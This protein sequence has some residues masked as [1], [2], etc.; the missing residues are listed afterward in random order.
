MF[1]KYE[2]FGRRFNEAGQCGSRD[3]EYWRVYAYFNFCKKLHFLRDLLGRKLF[4]GIVMTAVVNGQP[5]SAV[6][7]FI[8]EMKSK[9]FYRFL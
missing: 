3:G 7:K 6:K 8:E 9:R 4:H 1:D 2:I 5:E